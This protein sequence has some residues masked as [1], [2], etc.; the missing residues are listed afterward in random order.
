MKANKSIKLSAVRASIYLLVFSLSFS[1]LSQIWNFSDSLIFSPEE[2]SDL[3][4]DRPIIR[5]YN[6]TFFYLHEDIINND[7]EVYQKVQQNTLIFKTIRNVSFIFL[8]ILLLLQLSALISMLNRETV[9]LSEN[10][11]CIR[12]MALILLIWVV[13]DFLLY[14]SIQFFIPDYLVEDSINYVPLNEEFFRSILMET[15]HK[16]LLGAFAFYVISVV[17]KEGYQLKEQADY[18]I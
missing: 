14:Q 10:L 16:M 8:I 17:F 7:P 11:K 2:L 18:T 1:I 3:R 15:D 5:I 13:V 9:F 6:D 4:L 12:R